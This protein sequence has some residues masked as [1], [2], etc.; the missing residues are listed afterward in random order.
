MPYLTNLAATATWCVKDFSH[1]DRELS[2]FYRRRRQGLRR[3][4]PT[5]RAHLLTARS[6]LFAMMLRSIVHVHVS[7][8]LLG[9]YSLE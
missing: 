9:P 7:K 5:G 6:E 4:R 1:D 2:G 8:T 3:R